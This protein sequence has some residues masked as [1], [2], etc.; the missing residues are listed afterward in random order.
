MS[1]FISPS[2]CQSDPIPKYFVRPSPLDG[3]VRSSVGASTKPE[4][5]QLAANDCESQERD[6]NPNLPPNQV[7]NRN[8]ASRELGQDRG[9]VRG[10][11]PS[12]LARLQRKGK[13]Q[14]F[15]HVVCCCRCSFLGIGTPIDR[16]TENYYRIPSTS[17]CRSVGTSDRRS[18]GARDTRT[19]SILCPF[20][21]LFCAYFVSTVRV[22]FV[23]VLGG[24]LFFSLQCCD[25]GV[26]RREIFDDFGVR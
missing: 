13:G 16:V 21:Q 3:L 18:P 26:I 1:P 12:R 5:P 11:S 2:G 7:P 9:Q 6:R 24:A 10:S 17:V 22:R 25:L 8:Q 19:R 23:L 15:W 20:L 4:P 14:G